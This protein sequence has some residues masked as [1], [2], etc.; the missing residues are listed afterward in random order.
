MPSLFL[1]AL[2]QLSGLPTINFE[3]EDLHSVFLQRS[4]L[5]GWGASA[6]S[7]RRLLWDMEEAEMTAYS[8][9]HRIGWAQI[10][11]GIG[12]NK[13]PGPLATWRR[14]WFGSPEGPMSLDPVVSLPPLAQ[15]LCDS[16]SRF[17]LVELS[18]FQVTGS[19]IRAVKGDSLGYLVSGLGWFNTDLESSAEA[20]VS[21]EQG[22]LGDR[23]LSELVSRPAAEVHW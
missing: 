22:L 23:D 14:G 10:G 17:G 1:E 19:S 20:V 4:E 6:S 8:E 21:L 13:L 3:E 11:L 2:G 9:A 18:G 7:N 16:L 5:M 15:C 12:P